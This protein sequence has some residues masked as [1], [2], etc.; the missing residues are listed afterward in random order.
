VQE[1]EHNSNS[2]VS[3]SNSSNDKAQRNNDDEDEAVTKNDE[4]E[5]D[6]VKISTMNQLNLVTSNTC[7]AIHNATNELKASKN[8]NNSKAK[9]FS[10]RFLQNLN[11]KRNHGSDS[12]S[13]KSNRNSMSDVPLLKLSAGKVNNN[14]RPPNNAQM[15]SDGSDRS[16]KIK[17]LGRYFQVSDFY[18]VKL[19]F[20]SV[21][22]QLIHRLKNKF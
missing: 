21:S 17:I 6:S 9:G 15:P 5:T 11:F 12:K 10:A 22:Q 19:T 3:I 8:Q 18:G 13:H 7:D 1:C 14:L 4:D 20:K 16:K 2:V